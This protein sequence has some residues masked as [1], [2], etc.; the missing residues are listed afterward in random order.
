MSV[1]NQQLLQETGVVVE[2]FILFPIF[3]VPNDIIF[4]SMKFIIVTDD[5]IMKTGLPTEL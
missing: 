2:K 4:D 3:R 5:M 1:L